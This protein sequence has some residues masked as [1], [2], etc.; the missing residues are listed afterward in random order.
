[1]SGKHAK[2][3]LSREEIAFIEELFQGD[4]ASSLA[5]IRSI[6]LSDQSDNR[7]L[8]ATLMES[9]NLELKADIG[10]HRFVFPFEV[11]PDESGQMHLELAVPHIYELEKSIRSWRFQ[12]CDEELQLANYDQH[13]TDP[14]V[15]NISKSGICI[16]D[17]APKLGAQD[18]A[19]HLTLRLLEY[20]Q[21]V[22]IRCNMVRLAICPENPEYKQVAFK[23]EET[24][25]EVSHAIRRYLFECHRRGQ[26][27]QHRDRAHSARM[28]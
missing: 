22:K 10:A 18:D 14:T 8:L 2:N 3:I 27:A 16:M 7:L 23:F 9:Y 19:Y 4:T 12:P 24:A 21:P 5:G 20:E 1:M 13:F 28:D 26:I 11:V 6:T 15:I 25:P 17:T